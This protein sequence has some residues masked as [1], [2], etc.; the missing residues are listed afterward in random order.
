MSNRINPHV[1]DACEFCRG[2]GFYSV[3]KDP[4]REAKCLECGGTGN[5]NSDGLPRD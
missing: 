2:W 4:D 1:R 3:S 5:R